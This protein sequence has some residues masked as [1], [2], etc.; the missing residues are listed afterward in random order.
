MATDG[1]KAP[2]TNEDVWREFS[3]KHGDD[4]YTRGIDRKWRTL[5]KLIESGARIRDGYLGR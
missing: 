5:G 3:G 4:S 1:W 2:K